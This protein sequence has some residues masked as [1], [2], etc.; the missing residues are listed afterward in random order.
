MRFTPAGANAWMTC[1][2]PSGKGACIILNE[3]LK[4]LYGV[5]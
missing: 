3:K 1:L 2:K 4:S 5:F